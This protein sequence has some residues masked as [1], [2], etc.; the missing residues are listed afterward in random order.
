HVPPPGGPLQAPVL[1]EV[2]GEGPQVPESV[3]VLVPRQRSDDLV[4]ERPQLAQVRH[5]QEEAMDSQLLEGHDLTLAA[6]SPAG[7]DGPAGLRVGAG[8]LPWLPEST[9]D[10][11]RHD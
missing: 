10:P 5:L 11:D 9:A 2:A 4:G 8:D 6:E 1:A 3:L 7:L